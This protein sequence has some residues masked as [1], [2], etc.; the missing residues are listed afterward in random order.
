MY[1]RFDA[2]V[3]GA[4]IVGLATAREWIGRLPELRLAVLEKER[5]TAVH[6]TGRNS[7]VIHF[8]IYYEPG[9]L[10]ATLCV[11][12]ARL[13]KDDC[14]EREIPFQRAG[15]LIMA[16]KEDELMG[17]EELLRR[18]TANGVPGLEMVEERRIPEIEPHASGIRALYCPDASIVDYR[19]VAEALAEEL[20]TAGGSL[21]TSV[22]VERIRRSGPVWQL[23][24]N[25]PTLTTRWLITC[26]GLQSDRLAAMTGGSDGP[27]ILP[28]RGDYWCSSRS[29]RQWFE[30]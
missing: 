17:L 19:K 3:V 12:G 15:K 16:T 10:K 27:R 14:Q 11:R 28:F 7:G 24:T 8:G 26:A 5:A 21:K 9:S 2:V 23:E 18:G 22:K 29:A 1:M 30:A 25:G 20:R 13:I 4:G 6:Q